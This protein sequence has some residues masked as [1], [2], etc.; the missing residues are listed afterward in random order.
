MKRLTILTMV[1]I[2]VSSFSGLN[3]EAESEKTD[4]SLNFGG[5]GAY[6]VGLWTGGINMDFHLGDSL[7]LSP[8]VMVYGYRFHF[9][10]LLIAPSLI[11]NAKY[12]SL[13]FGAGVTKMFLVSIDDDDFSS[14][15][16]L[17]FNMGANVGKIR[18]TAFATT[19][20]SFSALL[21]GATIGLR[22]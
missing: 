6:G 2:L 9:D 16:L 4:L 8:E 13:F 15:F 22:F 12:Q 3:L 7:M 17:K 18:L 21:F 5:M 11:L 1:F 19:D 10:N 14:I 20:F